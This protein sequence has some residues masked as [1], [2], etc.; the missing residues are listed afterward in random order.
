MQETWSKRIAS[1]RSAYGYAVDNLALGGIV[2][3][4]AVKGIVPL[5]ALSRR[6]WTSED[7]RHRRRRVMDRDVTYWGEGLAPRVGH[8]INVS[9]GGMYLETDTPLEEG[10]EMTIN[11]YGTATDRLPSI[12]ARVVR[13]AASGMAV[14]FT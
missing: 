1:L 2:F 14:A 3:Q 13:R 7:R 9:R 10:R 11:F 5:N 8:M 12:Q 4:Q 6:H